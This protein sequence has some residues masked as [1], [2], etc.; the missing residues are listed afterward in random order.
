MKKAQMN[1]SDKSILGTFNV[2]GDK[3]VITDPC[4][5]RG[6]GCVIVDNVVPGM[7]FGTVCYSNEGSWG[8]R[9][10]RV[11][12]QRSGGTYEDLTKLLGSVFS[13]VQ[14]EGARWT[15]ECGVSVD[16]GQA[17]IFDEARYPRD[18]CGEYGGTGTFYGRACEATLNGQQS[19]GVIAEGV[20]AR[21]GYGDGE[22]TCE[23]FRDSNDRVL[24]VRI[25]FIGN[26]EHDEDECE[27]DQYE[28]D[29]N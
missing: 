12:A 16:S 10:C 18:E 7:W 25:T 6:G 2:T 5:S 1:Y 14:L 23:T 8:R 4:Y 21:S 19:G 22:Y 29:E 11:E 17:G 15:P 27:D 24:A 3:L 13:A 28:D 26:D 9:V 20:V